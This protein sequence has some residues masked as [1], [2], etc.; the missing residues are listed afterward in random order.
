ME[1]CLINL[2]KIQ[3]IHEDVFTYFSNNW[4]SKVGERHGKYKIG[5]LQ[6]SYVP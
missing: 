3:Y 5:S 4:R 6:Y 1:H 2:I